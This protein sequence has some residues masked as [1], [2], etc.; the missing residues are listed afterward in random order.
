MIAS[1]NC[2]KIS[3]ESAKF[4]RLDQQIGGTER[5]LNHGDKYGL[6]RALFRDR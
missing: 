5:T 6:H 3:V 4:L 2:R 1:L